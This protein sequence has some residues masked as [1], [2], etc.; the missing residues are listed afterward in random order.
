M[1]EH[2]EGRRISA[3]QGSNRISDPDRHLA[4]VARSLGWAQE[5]A[6]RGDY[7][8]ALG[9]VQAVEATG[10]LLSPAQRA[11]RQV[12]RNALADNLARQGRS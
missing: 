12:W 3:Q 4:A 5:S 7:A 11:T 8:D 1:V 10:D 2:G 6:D 9:W